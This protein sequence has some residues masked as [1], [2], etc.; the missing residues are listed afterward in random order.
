MS[1]KSNPVAQA[2]NE[3]RPFARGVLF[4]FLTLVVIGSAYGSW[5]SLFALNLVMCVVY[6]IA[7][8]AGVAGAWALHRDQQFLAGKR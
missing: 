5:H 2:P 6:T 3:N 4:A 8:L 7:A 1:V